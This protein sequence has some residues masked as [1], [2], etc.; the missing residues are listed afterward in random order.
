MY[1]C[2]CAAP[3]L[4]EPTTTAVKQKVLAAAAA[5]GIEAELQEAEDTVA[6][7][8]PYGG[9]HKPGVRNKKS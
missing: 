9:E 2:W 7:S 3:P 8:D 5:A 6:T 4:A 1:F